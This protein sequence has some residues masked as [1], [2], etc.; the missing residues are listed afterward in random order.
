MKNCKRVL[1]GIILV[2]ILTSASYADKWNKLNFGDDIALGIAELNKYCLLH[3]LKAEDVFWANGVTQDEIKAG[4]F[5]YLPANHVDMLAIWQNK[6]SWKSSNLVSTQKN[7]DKTVEKPAPVQEIKTKVEKVETPVKQT[8]HVTKME[9]VPDADLQALLNSVIRQKKTQVEEPEVKVAQVTETKVQEPEKIVASKPV[10]LPTFTPVQQ[11]R[12]IETPEKVISN[13]A[14][15]DKIL[16]STKKK[17][18]SDSNSKTFSDP[19]IV[20]SPNGDSAHGAMRLVISG[21]KVEVVKLP[22]NAVPRRPSMLDLDHTF[23]STPSYLPYYNLTAKPRKDNNFFILSNNYGGKMMWP[24]NGKVSSYFGQRGKRKHEGIDIPMP[25]GTPI[26][27]AKSGVVSRT[28]NNSTIGFRGYG[29][30]ALIDHGNG[31]QSF[32]AHCSSVAVSQGQRVMQ[33]QVIGFVGNTGRSTANHLHFE[34]RVNNA[35][36]NP[37]LYLGG[38]AQ[39]ASR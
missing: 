22:E 16:T 1:A 18:K 24:V 12:K 11:E 32:Y 9:Q 28:G 15:P 23:G 6:G 29:N 25:A 13:T 21:D 7:K 17:T 31:V 26:R 36:V 27:A 39:L 8:G 30:F 3:D 19:I 35:K 37:M 33:G 34:V 10:E 38:N 4:D 20:L 5:I 2:M 14:R